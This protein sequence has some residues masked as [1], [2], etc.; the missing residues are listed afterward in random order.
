M[1]EDKKKEKKKKEV[2][3]INLPNARRSLRRKKEMG[4]MKANYEDMW[5]FV[6]GIV[7][8][9]LVLFVLFGGI[10]QLAFFK[11]MTDFATNVGNFFSSIFDKFKIVPTDTGIYLQ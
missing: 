1:A 6:G 9:L 8:V 2:T 7:I 3:D 10:N 4:Q 5:K 11:A